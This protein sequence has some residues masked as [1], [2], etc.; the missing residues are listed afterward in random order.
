VTATF[1]EW[2][3]GAP[4]GWTA[5]EPLQVGNAASHFVSRC[6]RLSRRRRAWS[7]FSG[8]GLLDYALSPWCQT[9]GY[10]ES[11]ADAVAVLRAR[12]RDGLLDDAPIQGDVT[13]AT[14]PHAVEVL[15]AGF[16]CQDV[17]VAGRR[18]G[19]SGSRTSLVREVIRMCDTTNCK[20]VFLE[21]V[22]GIRSMRDVWTFVLLEL[23]QRRFACRWVTVAGTQVR[24]V[25]ELR[26]PC[27]P[28]EGPDGPK[29]VFT[30][31]P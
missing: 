5:L 8:T 16:P 26:R 29:N 1:A 2:L 12:I 31:F 25:R 17:S 3:M 15:V 18:A 23:M 20:Y 28:R 14:P 13:Q 6:G 11:S 27:R 21:N 19:L 10:V 4:E 22:D 9:V 30:M 7:L 24:V